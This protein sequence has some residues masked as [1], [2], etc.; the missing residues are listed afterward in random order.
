[1]IKTIVW[2]QTFG[3]RVEGTR[4]ILD[5]LT[6]AGI[7]V[8]PLSPGEVEGAGIVFFHEMSD[9]LGEFVRDASRGGAR[10]VLAVATGGAVTQQ[11][12]WQLLRHGA[13]DVL[14]MDGRAEV[15]RAAAARLTRW[16]EVDAI[17]DS[18]LVRDNLV[19]E[20]NTWRAVMRQLV[21]AAHFTD[22]PILLQGDTG[23][24]KELA[25]RLVHSLDPGHGKG[26]LVVVDCGAI[27]PELSGSEFFGHER[28][29]F[30]GAVSARDGAFALANGGT[31]FLDELGD[32]PLRLQPELLRAVQECTYKRV[33]SNMW[34]KT[35]FRLVSATHRDLLG[36]VEQGQFRGDLYY[37]IASITI[38]LP[39]L[40]DRSEDVL[41]L[42]R[43]FMSAIR[44]LHEPPE[45]EGI[46]ERYLVERAYP[47]NVRELR[48]LVMRIMHRHV[49]PGPI[50]AGDIPEDDRPDVDLSTSWLDIPFEGAIRRA[51]AQG[52]SL[53]EIGQAATETAIRLAVDIEGNLQNAARRLHVTDRALQMR[54]A[55]K[56]QVHSTPTGPLPPIA[57]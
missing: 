43:H 17:V 54:R 8:L 4:S 15:A 3:E 1:M 34:Q 13:S 35:H 48:Q 28:G 14:A 32:L 16:V 11:T 22:A 26:A 5:A 31:L 57:N 56:R 50:T 33:G 6:H 24:G 7:G 20:S 42:A 53:R 47:G 38:H 27:A 18:S 41:P 25:A 44:R 40:R 36:A 46:V 45:I 12:V 10:R 37:R 30:T 51:V 2:Q 29:S 9:R 21:E 23:S 49:G 19:G 55:A 52:V 39:S